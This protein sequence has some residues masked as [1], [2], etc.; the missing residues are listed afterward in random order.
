M[1]KSP[2][3]KTM[4][5]FKK[6][7]LEIA[8]NVLYVRKCKISSLNFKTKLKSQKIIQSKIRLTYLIWIFNVYDMDT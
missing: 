5:K 1:N 7:D 8:L 2:I 3:R 4:E 6:N